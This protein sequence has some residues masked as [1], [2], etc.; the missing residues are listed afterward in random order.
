MPP[1]DSAVACAGGGARWRAQ[2]EPDQHHHD[3]LRQPEDDESG[4]VATAGDH[5]GDRHHRERRARAE[6]GGGQPGRKAAL[7]GEPFQRVADGGAVDEPR[8]DPAERGRDVEQRQRAGE[9]VQHP[10]GADQH[11]AGADG[12]ARPDAVDHVAGQRQQP[13]L[14]QDEDGEGDLDRRLAPVMR[15]I[16]RRDEQRPAVLQVGDHHHAD[17][18]EDQLTPARV[19]CRHHLRGS[20]GAGSRFLRHCFNDPSAPSGSR[21]NGIC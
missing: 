20:P 21:A 10:G 14:A 1:G 17:N 9:A 15:L 13:G 5:V 3:A 12:E 19:Q 11:A 18:A 16:E 6:A 2:Q 7:V 4:L 8:P